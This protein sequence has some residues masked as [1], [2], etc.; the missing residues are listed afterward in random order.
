MKIKAKLTFNYKNS[1]KAKIALQSLHPDNLDFVQSK[2][3]DNVMVCHIKSSKIKSALAT[4]DDLIF[5]E[6][7][8]ENVLNMEIGENR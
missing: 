5:S 1:T 8:V 7:M 6:I 2:I 4:I 3:E